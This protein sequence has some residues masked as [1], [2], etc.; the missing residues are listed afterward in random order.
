M[1]AK[2]KKGKKQK[3]MKHT[4]VLCSSASFY[5]QVLE[6]RDQLKALGFKVLAPLTAGKM[7]RSGDFKVETYKTW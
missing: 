2:G 3:A 5:K 1:K 4:V 7:E 6:V